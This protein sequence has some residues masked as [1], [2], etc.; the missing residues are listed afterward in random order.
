MQDQDIIVVGASAGGV[1]AVSLLVSDL[2]PDLPAAV[3]VVIHVP[4]NAA[5]TLPAILDRAGP[6]P[7][8]PA[9]DWQPIESGRIYVARPDLHLL[10]YPGHVRTVRGPRENHARPAID[11]LFRSAAL[12]YGERVIGVV[13]TGAL[14]DGT[15]GLAAIKRQGGIALVQDPSDA[16]FPSMPM[17]AQVN[18]DVDHCLPLR[19]MGAILASI[20][21]RR[22]TSN[23]GTDVEKGSN[24]LE[25]EVRI[26]M[27]DASALESDDESRPGNPS[28]FGCPEC[29]GVLWEQPDAGPPRFRCRVGHAYS[30]ESLLASQ[31]DGFETALWTALRALEEK[32]ALSRRLSRRAHERN[33]P[34]VAA[35]FE[36]QKAGAEHAASVVHQL[37]SRPKSATADEPALS[38]NHPDAI[39][40]EVHPE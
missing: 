25:Y 14:D 31:H 8:L 9:E 3:F 23:G 12:A 2:P 21:R 20:V 10:I 28:P 4:A 33:M 11:P 1:E 32:A 26:S 13:L 27:L 16:L 35:R 17:S 30:A 29:G 15:A 6:L 39:V 19:E 24:G 34:E 22:A 36:E 37:L 7:S 38:G 40:P 18:V 5:S